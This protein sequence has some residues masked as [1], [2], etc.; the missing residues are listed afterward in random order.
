MA[1]RTMFSD[2]QELLVARVLNNSKRDKPWSADSVLSVAEP[3]QCLSGTDSSH[4]SGV[5]FA[6]PVYPGLLDE[7]IFSAKPG[8][9]SAMVTTDAADVSAPSAAATTAEAAA[10][11]SSS[12]SSEAQSDHIDGLLRSL[13]VELTSEQKDRAEQ[14]I[15]SYAHVFSRSEYDIG[16]TSIIPHRIDTGQNSP[17]FEQLRRHPTTQLPVIDE[18]VSHMLEHDV[19]EPAASPWCSNVVMVRKQDGTMRLCV[20]YRKLN[21]LTTK[22]KFPLPKIDTCLDTLNGCEFFSTCDLHWGY[23]QTEMDER[24]RDKTAFVT[25]KGQWR[26]KVLSFGLANAPSQFAR[27]MELVMSG[28]TY[29]VC[30]VYLDDILVFSKTFEEHLVRLATVFNRLD[31]YGLKLKPSK[32]SLFH[33]RYLFLDTLSAVMAL[34]VIRIR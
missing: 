19:I 15:R 34:S 16:R 32:C 4:T 3:V 2:K 10:A 5:V 8:C 7:S 24:D 29:D 13:P 27:I 28:L 6:E 17:H 18:H 21:C 31:R 1:A 22:D 14:L 20:D 11:G 26:F 23:W 30:L 12:P 9:L 25:R 33:V